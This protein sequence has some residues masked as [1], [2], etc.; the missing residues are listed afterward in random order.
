MWYTNIQ[1]QQATSQFQKHSKLMPMSINKNTSTTYNTF[2]NISTLYRSQNF[3][4]NPQY[5]QTV[6]AEK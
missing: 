6:L 1:S 4:E 3:G 5:I 2:F